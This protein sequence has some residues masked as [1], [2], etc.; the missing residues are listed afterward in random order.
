MVKFPYFPE[1]P[2]FFLFSQMQY[3]SLHFRVCEKIII[4]VTMTLED[5]GKAGVCQPIKNEGTSK[6]ANEIDF[7]G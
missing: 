5:N 3:V 7:T 2:C 4:N 6:V 1:I